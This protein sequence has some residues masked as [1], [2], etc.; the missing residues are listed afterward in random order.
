MKQRALGRFA[1][2]HAR[3]KVGRLSSAGATLREQGRTKRKENTPIAAPQTFVE[4]VVLEL[5]NAGGV[6][7]GYLPSG[8]RLPSQRHVGGLAGMVRSVKRFAARSEK[9]Y[10]VQQLEYFNS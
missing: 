3:N 7:Q 10:L 1:R 5:S 8:L 9:P 4:G 6:S 2:R